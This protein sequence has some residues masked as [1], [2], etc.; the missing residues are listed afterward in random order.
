LSGAAFS[1]VAPLWRHG[2]SDG[3][4]FLTLPAELA[5]DIREIASGQPRPFGTVPVVVAIGTTIWST[6]LFADRKLGSYVLPVKTDVRDAAGLV[7]G[8]QV[9]CRIELDV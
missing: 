5:E 3:W 8:D 7:A 1:F 2:G 4:H 9:E 6:S